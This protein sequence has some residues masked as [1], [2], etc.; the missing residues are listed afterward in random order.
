MPLLRRARAVVTC[1]ALLAAGCL[2]MTGLAHADTGQSSGVTCSQGGP[3][4]RYLV[5]FPEGTS[6]SAANAE[7]T[8]ACGTTTIYYPQI[9][10][11]VATSPDA[12]FGDRMGPNRAYSAQALAYA[13]ADNGTERKSDELPGS[14]NDVGDTTD[15]AQVPSANQTGAQWDMTMIQA[16]LAHRVNE[17][18]PSVVVGVLD[19]G[20][21][22]DQPNLA[23][24]VDAAQ[25]AGCVTGAP[26]TTPAAWQP[27]TS[28]HGTHVAGTIA[29]AD[30][31]HGIAGV[32]PGVK[33]ASVKVVD[34]QGYIYPEA[35]VCGF[36]WAAEQGFQVTNSSYYI[37]PW[38]F[39]CQHTPGQ[40]VVYEAVRRAVAYATAKG[41][42]NVAA[43]GN[44]AVD[45]TNPGVDANSP[46]NV[47]PD[48]RQTRQL[49]EDCAEL[50]A[51]LPGVVT[52]SAVGAQQ[53]KASYSSYGLGAI[54]VTAPGG[55]PLQAN[56]AGQACVLSTVPDG[57]A[58][59]CGT[60]MAAPHAT[61][62]AA[63]L[64]STHP[65]AGA[66]ALMRLLEDQATPVTCPADYDLNDSGVQNAYCTGDMSYN[67]FYGYGMVNAL[68]AVTQGLA[69]AAA[70]NASSASDA[71]ASD[72]GAAGNQVA[73]A[74][75]GGAVNS[76]GTTSTAPTTSPTVTTDPS[77]TSG[78]PTGTTAP[79]STDP[80]TTDTTT[81]PAPTTDPTEVTGVR[82]LTV[83]GGW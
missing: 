67:S 79:S 48:D 71:N 28:A 74:A 17:G 64:A 62:V 52:V 54:D 47:D 70:P 66:K 12:G 2:A 59:S 38:I 37:D 68:A 49:G 77:S 51:G 24:A 10:V 30:N 15:P 83:I 65:H 3:D 27:T 33:V 34:D 22:P 36:M 4:L 7:I 40:D 43:A 45:L 9:A 13:D 55:D 82:G 60:S 16:N 1:T 41:V 26:D 50:P 35:A 56:A 63:L 57:Y 20:I 32:A 19:S 75:L 11:A 73:G 42:L 69:P 6:G 80:S 76:T 29:A 23:G 21:D 81:V 78:S 53:V 72:L 25:S 8:A 44:Q 14:G 39:T 5:I 61:G 46:D 58:S 31:G 18:S